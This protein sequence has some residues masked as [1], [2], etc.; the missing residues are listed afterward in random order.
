VPLLLHQNLRTFGGGTPA[1]NAAYLAALPGIG[2]ALGVPVAVAGFTELTNNG[3]A[4]AAIANCCGAIG[5][6][7]SA[8]IACRQ[9]AVGN[10]YEYIGVGT[11]APPLGWGRI[12]VHV[13]GVPMVHLINNIYPGG[14][15]NNWGST[16]PGPA[17]L[18]Y[19]HLVYVVV[20]IGGS[21][22][23]VGF[24]HNIWAINDARSVII[25]RLP[26]AADLMVQHP[27]MA[28]GQVVYVCGDF[29]VNPLPRNNGNTVMTPYSQATVAPPAV[30]PA[31]SPQAVLLPAQNAAGGVAGG[32]T[33][34]GAGS[35]YDYTFTNV[36]PA[37][38][39]F[40]GLVFPPVPAISTLTMDCWPGGAPIAG[41]AGNMSDHVCSLLQ[42]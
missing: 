23:A 24:V 38:P 5:L 17:T 36:Q 14:N 25:Q 40:P 4:S 26:D 32:T 20:N 13:G 9:T 22:V 35:L 27:A 10:A 12:I 29:N 42:V 3:A 18:D 16:L 19:Q 11:A 39:P 37:W 30:P 34:T 41:M 1:R 31:T 7:N 8:A 33:M 21:N 2:A 15:L 28:G 6:P